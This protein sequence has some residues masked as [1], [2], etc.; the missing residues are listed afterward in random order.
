MLIW[1]ALLGLLCGDLAVVR[2]GL[3]DA[4]LL[5]CS[6]FL[7]VLSFP[8]HL[9]SVS[10]NTLCVRVVV[11]SRSNYRAAA[12]V[13]NMRTANVKLRLVCRICRDVAFFLGSVK[14]YTQRDARERPH[15]GADAERRCV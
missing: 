3:V 13:G 1:L 10:M 14:R 9:H 6:G 5:Q 7:L 8:S 11:N 4:L 2:I 12:V 15:A